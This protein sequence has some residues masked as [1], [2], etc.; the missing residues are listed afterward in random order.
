MNAVDNFLKE[1][2]KIV[3]YSS[4]QIQFISPFKKGEQLSVKKI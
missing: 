3:T 2:K 1:E 4:E